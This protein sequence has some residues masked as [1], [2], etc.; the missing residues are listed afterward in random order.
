MSTGVQVWLTPWTGVG[1]AFLVL[2]VGTLGVR[3]AWRLRL[4][5]DEYTRLRPLTFAAIPL[6][7][8]F[9]L[10]V[11]ERFVMLTS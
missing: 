10:V 9:V 7:I 11:L 8:G 5:P 4:A 3:E 1:V 6:L 2:L